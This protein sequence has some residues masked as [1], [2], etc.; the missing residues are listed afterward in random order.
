MNINLIGLNTFSINPL[1]N[2]FKQW[3]HVFKNVILP[4][5]GKGKYQNTIDW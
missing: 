3:N 1:Y 2:N 5:F 4:T